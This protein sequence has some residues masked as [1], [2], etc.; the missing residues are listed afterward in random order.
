MFTSANSYLDQIE[1]DQNSNAVNFVRSS[2]SFRQ[3][4]S[5]GDTQTS[6]RNSLLIKSFQ[7]E[8]AYVADAFKAGKISRSL[9]DQLSQSI[10]TDQMA[11]MEQ[12]SGTDFLLA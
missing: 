4:R 11:Y 7:Y 10:S 1:D 9:S 2:Y 5:A 8:Y 6:D 3:S 12:G